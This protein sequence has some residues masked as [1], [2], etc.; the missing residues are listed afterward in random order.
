MLARLRGEER[1]EESHRRA[2]P[3]DV[4]LIRASLHRVD[5]H[6]RVIAHREVLRQYVAARQ[7]MNDKRAVADAFDAGRA[8]VALIVWGAVIVYCMML[9]VFLSMFRVRFSQCSEFVSLYAKLR[10]LFQTIAQSIENK[11]YIVLFFY[12]ADSSDSSD[13]QRTLTIYFFTTDSSD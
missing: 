9:F 8:I 4:N 13:L 12:N 6:L 1:R 10:K 11:N 5:N 7:R 2:R 3:L